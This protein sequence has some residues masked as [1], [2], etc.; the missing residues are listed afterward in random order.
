[1][2]SNPTFGTG[3]EKLTEEAKMAVTRKHSSVSVTQFVALIVATIALSL[4]VD[5]GRKVALYRHR[6]V[7]E[8]RLDRAIEYEENRRDYLEWLKGYIQTPGFVDS[9]ARREWKLVKPGETSVVPNL[10]GVSGAS[11]TLPQEE[12]LPSMGSHWRE[13][14]EFFFNDG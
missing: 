1:V 9:W 5:F 11:Q 2:G 7:E 6:Q 10:P 13:W 4:V 12:G 14:W 3:S 8:A